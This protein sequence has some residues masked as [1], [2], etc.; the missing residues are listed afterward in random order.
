MLSIVFSHTAARVTDTRPNILDILSTIM[1]VLSSSKS[2]TYTVACLNDILKSATFL[3]ALLMLSINNFSNFGRLPPLRIISPYL[4]R[5][6]SF[7]FIPFLCYIYLRIVFTSSAIF[8]D[9]KRISSSVVFCEKLM[10]IAPF[11]ASCDNPIAI[12]TWLGCGLCD[13]HA[14]PV[15][16]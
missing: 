4:A 14:E 6:I 3:S 1:S 9:A 13:E 16:T 11:T 8:C 7:T 5:I 2:S 12:S 15:E 10:R